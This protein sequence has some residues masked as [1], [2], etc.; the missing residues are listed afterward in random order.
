MVAVARELTNTQVNRK[1]MP[2]YSFTFKNKL[3]AGFGMLMMMMP[4]WAHWHWTQ[5]HIFGTIIMEWTKKLSFLSLVS[6]LVLLYFLLMCPF[7]LW[8]DWKLYYHQYITCEY[9]YYY[10]SPLL[11]CVIGAFL[12]V[13]HIVEESSSRRRRR[14]GWKPFRQRFM[15]LRRETWSAT[16]DEPDHNEKECYTRT[17]EPSTPLHTTTVHLD[18]RQV[19]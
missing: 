6:F 19:S 4:S 10:F 5:Y 16:R 8:T 2:K 17:G 14:Y 15:L 18:R 12:Q 7:L 11:H 3:L 9:Y 1:Y 13:S